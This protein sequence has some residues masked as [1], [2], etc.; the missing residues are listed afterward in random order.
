MARVIGQR[1]TRS[2]IARVAVPGQ[3]EAYNPSEVDRAI[4][5]VAT[6]ANGALDHIGAGGTSAHPI[7][8]AA[9]AGFAPALDGN[10]AHYL[11]GTGAWSTPSGGG[12][13]VTD[14]D[15]GDITVSGGGATW[16]VD[17]AVLDP[18]ALKTRSIATTAPLAGGGDL[19]A[20]RTL[21]VATFG[22]GNSGVVP[23]SGG[24]TVNFL[25]ADGTWNAPAGGGGGG[26]DDA[27][28]L[29][30]LL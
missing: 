30:A 23:A 27:L 1:R 17:A 28:A 2:V 10:A 16:T 21:T 22:A 4:E 11:D 20:D 9:A 6:A 25:R 8:T 26:I 3:P 15:K 18:Y 12:G 14:G 7:A 13:G 5:E 24:G 29:G 19:T